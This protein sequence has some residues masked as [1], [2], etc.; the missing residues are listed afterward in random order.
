L[1][2]GACIEERGVWIGVEAAEADLFLDERLKK[3]IVVM[4][5]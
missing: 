3:G 1:G 2:R 4:I 5:A